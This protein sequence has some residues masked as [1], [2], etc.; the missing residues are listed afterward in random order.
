MNNKNLIG[1]YYDCG[2]WQEIPLLNSN[3]DNIETDVMNYSKRRSYLCGVF[4]NPNQIGAMIFDTPL[5][6]FLHGVR[7]NKYVEMIPLEQII[8]DIKSGI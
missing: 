5:T 2:E 8:E 1:A 4:D 6:L 7:Y 3:T